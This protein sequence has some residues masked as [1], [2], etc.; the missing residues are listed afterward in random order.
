VGEWPLRCFMFFFGGGEVEWTHSVLYL[1]M[2]DS[3]VFLL[4]ANQQTYPT[5]SFKKDNKQSPDDNISY[6][7]GAARKTVTNK[8]GRQPPHT[9]PHGRP[10][11]AYLVS[12]D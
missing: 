4:L 10:G 2:A 3:N 8:T 12:H 6:L 5:Q 7:P 1:W 9:S 11:V